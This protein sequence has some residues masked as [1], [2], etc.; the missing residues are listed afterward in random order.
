MKSGNSVSAASAARR[1]IVRRPALPGS[2]AVSSRVNANGLN[3]RALKGTRS[4]LAIVS[5]TPSAAKPMPT[6]HTTLE[7]A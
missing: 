6:A 2:P 5:R 7:A 1:R 3:A 4:A